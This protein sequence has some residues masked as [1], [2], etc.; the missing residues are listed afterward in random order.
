MSVDARPTE[1]AAAIA[2]ALLTP[3]HDARGVTRVLVVEDNPADAELVAEYFDG[4]ERRDAPTA[5]ERADR[6]A[7]AVARI[8]RERFDVVLLDLS[9]PD[10]QGLEALAALTAAAPDV[11]IVVMTG[12]ADDQVALAA[13]HAGAQDYLIKGADDGRV[14]RRAVRYAVERH[15]LRRDREALLARERAARADAERAARLRDEVLGI[16]SHDLR[17]PLGT[18]VM[19]AHALAEGSRP[20]VTE[21]A[22]LVGIIERSAE[23]ALRVI[24]DLLDVTAIEAGRLRIHREPMTVQ[25]ITDMVRSLFEVQ[26]RAAGV[27]LDIRVGDAPRWIEADVDRTVQAVG[28]LVSNAIA[29]TPRGGQVRLTV[30]RAAGPGDAVAFR[31]ADTGPGI[32]PE[33]LPHLFDRFWQART[34]RRAGAGLGLAIARGIAEGHGGRIEVESTPGAG[35]VFTLV[36]PTGA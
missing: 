11:P 25:A 12:L 29:F 1:T 9:L 32:A 10:A 28:N 14:V 30:A 18:I 13:L 27:Q 36:L 23:W 4:A 34:S 26:A 3:E 2:A 19:S 17:S 8:G 24:R 33:Q 35:S 15:R 22:D 7:T 6:L 16:V 20:G 5:I 21:R 31:V